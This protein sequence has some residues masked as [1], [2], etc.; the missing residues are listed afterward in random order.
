MAEFHSDKLKQEMKTH[1]KKL[2]VQEK[3]R[4]KGGLLELIFKGIVA[5]LGKKSRF[6]LTLC[7]SDEVFNAI[8]IV[9]FIV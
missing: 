5:L 6:L 4:E 7:I 2:H 9:L 8:F 3:D 1:I